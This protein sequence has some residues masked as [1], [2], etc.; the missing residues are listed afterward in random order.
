MVKNM[1]SRKRKASTAVGAVSREDDSFI[2][3]EE[4]TGSTCLEEVEIESEP[5]TKGSDDRIVT[6]S[7]DA[8]PRK[9]RVPKP[10]GSHLSAHYS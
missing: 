1:A 7:V 5:D 2:V 8:A 4:D 10:K 9:C 6:I 3:E